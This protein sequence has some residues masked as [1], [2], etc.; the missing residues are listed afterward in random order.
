MGIA[1]P[2]DVRVDGVVTTNAL[3]PP[4]LADLR[5]AAVVDVARRLAVAPS[6]LRIEIDVEVA[7]FVA[8]QE[9]PQCT[10]ITICL[11]S[12]KSA[13]CVFPMGLLL[14]MS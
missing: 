5:E 8:P 6:V 9:S 1:R 11:F 10:S 4:E 13:T 7:L 12:S 14:R 3:A 2:V